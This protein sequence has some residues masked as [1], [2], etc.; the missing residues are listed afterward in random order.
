MRS[1]NPLI[2]ELAGTV[3]WL[4]DRMRC[5]RCR[6]VGTWKPHGGFFD[7][8]DVKRKRRWL[9]KWCGLYVGPEGTQTAYPGTSVW[10]LVE[11]DQPIFERPE[12]VLILFYHRAGASAVWP[13]RG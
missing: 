4:R 2:H 13:W 6:A 7:K 5:P 8:L 3:P 10:Q 12:T 1:L 11:D 9:C